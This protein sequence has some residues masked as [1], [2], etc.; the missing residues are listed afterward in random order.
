MRFSKKKASKQQYVGRRYMSLRIAIL[1]IAAAA[2]AMVFSHQPN[3][4]VF[5]SSNALAAVYRNGILEINVPYDEHFAGSGKLHLEILDPDDKQLGEA[6][7]TLSTNRSVVS[8]RASVSLEKDVPI[9]D[10]AWY[11]LKISSG[12]KSRIVS[13]SEILELPVVR[14]FAQRSYAVGSEA[15]VRVITTDSHDGIPLAG[16]RIKLELVNGEQSEILFSGRTDSFGTARVGFDLPPASYGSRQ[17]RVTADTSLGQVIAT[18][19][20]KLDRRDRILLTSDK[21]IYQ[22]GQTMHLRALAL[23]GPTHAAVANQPLTLEVEDGKGNKVFKKHNTTD[24]F[25]IAAA[26]FELADEVNFGA[27][28]VRAIL[29]EGDGQAVQEKTVTVDRYTLPKFKLEISLDGDAKKPQENGNPAKQGGYYR[30]GDTVSGKLVAK[31]MFGKP[32]TNADVVLTLTTFDVQSVELARL[33][34]KTDAEGNFSF[35]SKLPD[36]L[37]GRS[38]QQGSAP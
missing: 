27:Y 22:P 3:D 36:F 10:L 5:A 33:T 14:I 1:I 16:S 23:D 25:G 37:A 2:A 28:H 9:E 20:V 12:A 38:M 30:P 32:I 24:S 31:Y 29:G 4:R 15:A 19:P 17:F 35:S 21:P 8:W 6:N 11:R 34:G 7:K 18:E 26:D 13:L